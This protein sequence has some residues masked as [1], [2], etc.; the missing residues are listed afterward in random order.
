MKLVPTSL[1]S[2]HQ[3]LMLLTPRASRVPAT[4][5]NVVIDPQRYESI[6]ADMQKMRGRIYLEDGAIGHQQLASDGRHCSP[7]DPESWHLLTLDD[8]G[9]VSGCVRY[10]QHRNTVSFQELALR[11]CAL[12]ESPEWREKL[13]SAVEAELEAARLQAISYVEVGGWAL[14]KERR[15]TGEALRTALATYGLAQILGGCVG[16][17]TATVRNSSSSILRRIGGRALEIGGEKLPA[18]Y[19]PQYKC[20]MEIVRF[21][22]SSPNPRYWRWIDQISATL[23]NVPVLTLPFSG[24]LAVAS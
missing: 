9:S 15:C 11:S 19:D 10:R 12:A 2:A 3:Q 1:S 20:Q 16:V 4:F 24:A 8:G 6:L 5:Q 17:A 22:S 14:A 21:S 18:Y 13:R 23:L 7:L